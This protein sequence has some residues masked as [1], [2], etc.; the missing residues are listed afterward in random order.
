MSEITL[1]LQRLEDGN[2]SEFNKLPEEVKKKVVWREQ[3]WL[4]DFAQR[5]YN[6]S[7]AFSATSSTA[8]SCAIGHR[9]PAIVCRFKEQTSKGFMW[10]DIGLG[11][12][13]FDDDF[14]ESEKG[15]T[16]AVLAIVDDQATAKAKA[17]K[18]KAVADDRMK[19]VMDVLR[20]EL[21]A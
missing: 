17:L 11:E 10:R 12:W 1:L 19:R 4:T 3:Y 21:E 5:V 9:V 14:D 15:L 8:R 2:S 18:A 16:P 7:A 20:A 13:L 6:R